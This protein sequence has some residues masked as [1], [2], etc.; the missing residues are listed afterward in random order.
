MRPLAAA[1]LLGCL[2]AGG[3]G[4]QQVLLGTEG[5]ALFTVSDALA[6]P[7][8]TIDL[9]SQLRRGD[10]L[11]GRPGYVIRYELDGRPYRAAQTGADGSAVVAWTAP[12]AGDFVFTVSVA[13]IGMEAAPP[14]P[15]ELL[16]A[17]RAAAAPILITDMDKTTVL[18]GF[19]EVLIGDPAPM[20]HSA[21]VLKDLAK[22][23]TIVYLT[24]RPDYFGPK[25]RDWLVR[26]GYPRGPVLLSTVE[27]F[28]SGSGPFKTAA[29][30]ELRKR[31]KKIEIGVG[32]KVSDAQAYFDNGM[33]SFLIVTVEDDAKPEDLRA[34]AADIRTLPPAV[35]VVTDWQQVQQAVREGTHLPA[36]PVIEMLEAEA[37]QREAGKK[38]AETSNSEH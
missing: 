21:A 18:G 23:Y 33:E 26:H 3:C 11:Q 30:A 4:T 17:C 32:D 10:L 13:P 19:D 34:L 9:H 36:A 20:P 1:T 27:E 7:G 2:L 5:E 38:P 8:Q 31:F 12:R 29:L 16:V 15:R 37:K 25:S 6:L 28:L 24:H 22:D 35:N 14:A